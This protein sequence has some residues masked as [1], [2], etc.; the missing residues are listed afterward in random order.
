LKGYYFA[1]HCLSGQHK[2]CVQSYDQH[3]S[4]KESY[5]TNDRDV[6]HHLSS[7]KGLPCDRQHPPYNS[8]GDVCG[9]EYN[10]I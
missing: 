6:G 5:H 9:L 4:N 10:G 3:S 7:H 2:E 1:H 8:Q